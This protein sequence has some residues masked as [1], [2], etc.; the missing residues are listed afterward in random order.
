[1]AERWAMYWHGDRID[2]TCGDTVKHLEDAEKEA[3]AKIDNG[4]HCKL[5]MEWSEVR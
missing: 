2:L 1:M 4:K 3:P 5:K